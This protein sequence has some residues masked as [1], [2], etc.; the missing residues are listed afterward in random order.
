MTTISGATKL[1]SRTQNVK[2]VRQVVF[3]FK[4]FPIKIKIF[5]KPCNMLEGNGC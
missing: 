4:I 5:E 3:F 1:L 2:N